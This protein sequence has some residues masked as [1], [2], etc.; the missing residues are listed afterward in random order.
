MISIS[1]YIYK[2][3]NENWE[4]SKKDQYEEMQEVLKGKSFSSLDIFPK[5]IKD[6]ECT[7][8]AKC[9][10]KYF[11]F[12]VQQYL[13]CDYAENE[14]KAELERLS[15]LEVVDEQY[16]L[17]HSIVY[18]TESF[19]YLAYVMAIVKRDMTSI[20]FPVKR[21]RQQKKMDD[22]RTLY[23]KEYLIIDCLYIIFLKKQID[24]L[25]NYNYNKYCQ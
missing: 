24:N 21:L 11:D 9:K 23:R 12:E 7:Y 18:D 16:N 5:R 20:H 3:A 14:F 1:C 4:T 19:C 15:N 13:L 17:H 8:Y 2:T 25:S 10:R 6:T 22:V